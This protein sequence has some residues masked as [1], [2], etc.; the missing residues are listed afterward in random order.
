[1]RQSICH[2]TAI[3]AAMK[4]LLPIG[5]FPPISYFAYFLETEVTI[6]KHEHFIKQ[7][8]RNRCT[9]IGANGCLNLL[10]PRTKSNDRS[11]IGTAQIHNETDWKTLHWRSLEA[12]YRKSPYFEF[13][14]DDLRPLFKKTHTY[15]FELGLESIKTICNLLEMDFKPDFTSKHESSF[16][17]LDLRNSWNKQDYAKQNPVKSFPR[18]IQVFSDRHEFVPDLSILDLLFCQGPRA[19][20]S[21]QQLELTK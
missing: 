21:L 8:L 3:F 14:E 19:V 5:Y 17:G 10:V 15:H 12:A 13:Y 20:D 6:E 9:I 2:S 1:M 18:Y 4:V 11:T 7:S 16:E